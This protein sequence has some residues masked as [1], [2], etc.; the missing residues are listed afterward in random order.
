MEFEL[1][2]KVG[3]KAFGGQVTIKDWDQAPNK[4]V[5][6]AALKRALEK[7]YNDAVD[8]AVKEAMNG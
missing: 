8:G 5:A 7:M 1:S 2:I 3:D 4:E 6:T